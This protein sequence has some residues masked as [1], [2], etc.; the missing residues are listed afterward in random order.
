MGVLINFGLI[1]GGLFTVTYF[2]RVIRE[3]GVSGKYGIYG[4]IL[5]GIYLCFFIY[6]FMFK[7]SGVEFIDK[8]SILLPYIL[9]HL[10]IFGAMFFLITYL[11]MLPYEM[12]GL[13]Q[14]KFIIEAF[15]KVRS[16]VKGF[17]N[18][19]NKTSRLIARLIFC[20]NPFIIVSNRREIAFAKFIKTVILISYIISG[21]ILL[22]V[23][24]N[25]LENNG[26]DFNIGYLK[27]EYELY[28]TVFVTSLIPF[29]INYI[30]DLGKEASQQ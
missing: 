25:H 12:Y 10:L 29:T 24:T 17:L 15:G 27:R 20:I 14:D 28:K 13:I 26:I 11:M 19:Y 6:K 16:K 22:S 3:E 5:V 4:G 1:I 30:K 8:Y 18:R 2:V 23:F 7:L 9:S 21:I